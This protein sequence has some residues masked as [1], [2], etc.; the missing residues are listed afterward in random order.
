MVLL[1]T[2]RRAIQ[3][4]FLVVLDA[5]L[6]AARQA[7]T[8]SDATALRRSRCSRGRCECS[9]SSRQAHLEEAQAGD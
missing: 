3:L 4:L 5:V 7:D 2:H 9:S 8:A 6:R 1:T